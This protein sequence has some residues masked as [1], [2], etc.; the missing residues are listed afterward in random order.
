MEPKALALIIESLE[1]HRERVQKGKDEEAK[2]Q[3]ER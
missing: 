1:R 2:N 3:K